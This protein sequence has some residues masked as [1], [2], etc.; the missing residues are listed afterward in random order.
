MGFSNER[1]YENAG[2]DFMSSPLDESTEEL[3]TSDGK[4]VRYNHQKKWYGVADINGNLKTFYS[5]NDGADYW[6]DAVE[7]DG[8]K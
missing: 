7:R 6:K 2:I 4:R 8:K 5:P 1:E 3:L